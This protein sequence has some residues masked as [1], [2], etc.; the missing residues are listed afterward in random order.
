MSNDLLGVAVEAWLIAAA[1]AL[2][3]H[4]LRLARISLGVGSVGLLALALTTLPVG[5]PPVH[6]PLCIGVT[7]S[8]L[9]LSPD[10]LRL[11]A[12]GL[13][14]AILC[15]WLGTPS[16]RQAG[17]IF[18]MV[19]SLIGALGVFGLQDAVNFLI[20]RE[21]MS[22]GGA[23]MIPGEDLSV[24]KGRTVLFMLSLL[25]AGSVALMLAFVPS[26]A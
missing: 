26:G 16:R 19:A 14:G 10:A 5:A 21:I 17:R 2:T 9:V 7:G 23:A 20:A 25:E 22:L 12:F 1:L 6:T 4:A 15:A 24:D 8:T 13:P 11:M 3:N 18:G